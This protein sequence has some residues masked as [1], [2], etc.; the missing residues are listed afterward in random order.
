MTIASHRQR[1]WITAQHAALL[2]VVLLDVLIALFLTQ[3]IV[4]YRDYPFDGDEA[5]HANNGLALALDLQAGNFGAFAADFYAQGFYPPGFSWLKAVAFVI[6]GAS[7]LVGRLFSVVC[8]FLAALVIYAIGAELDKRLGWLIGLVAVALTLTAQWIMAASAKV[9]ME[10]PGLLAISLMLWAYLRAMKQPT[11]RRLILVSVL[12]ALVFLTKYTYGLVVIGTLALTEAT[13]IGS[14]RRTLKSNW[15]VIARRWVWL[16]G[17]LGLVLIA[18]FVGPGKLDQ[19][20]S[21]ATSQPRDV[22]WL[23]VENLLFYPR[24]IALHYAPSPIFALVILAGVIWAI[25]RWRDVQLRVLLVFLAIGLLEMLINLPKN[26]RFVA[27]YIPAAFILTGAL[28]AWWVAGWSTY[29]ARAKG[30]LLIAA[31][32]LAVCVVASVPVVVERFAAFPALMQ[33]SYGTDPRATDLAGWI[34]AQI[35]IGQR[36]YLVNP[37]DQ[38]SGMALEWY[39]ATHVLPVNGRMVEVSVPWAQLEQPTPENVQWMVQA[40]RASGAQ[41]VVALAGGPEGQ[42]TWSDYANALGSALVPVTHQNFILEQDKVG[43]WIKESL[44]TRDGLQAAKSGRHLKIQLKVTV[45]RLAW[46]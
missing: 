15:R 38:F 35:P 32:A 41:Y 13:L 24:S 17:P 12:A 7:P 28:L 10:A 33:V 46:Q 21:Y 27:T 5:I 29:W 14:Q 22:A 9:L 25:T 40:I 36:F 42:P 2:S 34:S 18:W 11:A 31:V 20:V 43:Q 19:F 6:F 1:K 39:Q 16:F 3:Q 23:T 4:A 37:W 44:L 8:L 26:P 45:Y 30:V